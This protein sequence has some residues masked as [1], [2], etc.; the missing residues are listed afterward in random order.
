M[1]SVKSMLGAS[2]VESVRSRSSAHSVTKDIN[3]VEKDASKALM[4]VS[5]KV[6]DVTKQRVFVI[7]L[8]TKDALDR[9]GSQF[10]VVSQAA[11]SCSRTEL[12][13]NDIEAFQ[14][15]STCPGVVHNCAV[16]VCRSLTKMTDS[17]ANCD[18]VI[19]IVELGQAEDAVLN[20][21][22]ED[23]TETVGSKDRK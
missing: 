11:I 23:G 4:A 20:R 18:A 19:A 6:S 5:E 1:A 13:H 2:R 21:A 15:G 16:E 9:V 3:K 14:N 8:E 10:K 22:S 12:K 17:M 7:G